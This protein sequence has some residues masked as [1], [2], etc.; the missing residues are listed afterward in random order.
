MIKYK[1]KDL[2]IILRSSEA[3]RVSDKDE[4]NSASLFARIPV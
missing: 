4:V 1:S 2:K 3:E